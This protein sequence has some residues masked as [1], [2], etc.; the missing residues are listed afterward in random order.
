ME[1]APISFHGLVQLISSVFM[2]LFTFFHTLIDPAAQD[3]FTRGD[4]KVRGLQKRPPPAP[5][6]G[7]GGFGGGGGGGGTGGRPRGPHGP[8]RFVTMTQVRAQ[9]D[10]QRPA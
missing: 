8:R 6:G 3:R 2:T 1:T 7:G 10:A 5:G 9:M 4:S